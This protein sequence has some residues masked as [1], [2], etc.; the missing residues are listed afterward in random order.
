MLSLIR[1]EYNDIP[2]PSF[3]ISCF[4]MYITLVKLFQTTNANKINSNAVAGI[5]CA[6]SIPV[7]IVGHP[8]RGRRIA[9]AMTAGRR[10]ALMVSITRN[11]AMD[12]VKH[13]ALNNA[14]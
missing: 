10:I 12:R 8:G 5:H 11:P 6:H 13:I 4:E 14:T 9:W 3:C 1:M 2:H 7:W